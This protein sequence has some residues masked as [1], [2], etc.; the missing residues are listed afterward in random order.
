MRNGKFKDFLITCKLTVQDFKGRYHVKN[1]RK[2]KEGTVMYIRRRFGKAE[3]LMSDFLYAMKYV[4]LAHE[5]GYTPYFDGDIRGGVFTAKN[6]LSAKDAKQYKQVI[7]SG[8]GPTHGF[9][10]KNAPAFGLFM[11]PKKNEKKK[12]LLDEYIE[13]DEQVLEMVKKERERICPQDCLG[14][15]LRGTDYLRLKPPGHP[16]QPTVEEVLEDIK[17]IKQR[18]NLKYIF[19]VTEDEEIQRKMRELFP[20][21]VLTVSFDRYVEGYEGGFVGECIKD[22]AWNNKVYV[23]KTMLL[24]ECHSF[25][26]GRT[27]GSLVA[28]A[29]NGGAYQTTA[30]FEK[31]FYE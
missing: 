17:L 13:W 3:G 30:M 5:K 23:A 9:F 31:G 4:E 28:L 2:G 8:W 25:V 18:E 10:C 1:R 11:S 22:V 15:Y 24:A 20:D 21:E 26:G 19:L 7:Y 27:N 14:V 12:M 6:T 29:M 16:V